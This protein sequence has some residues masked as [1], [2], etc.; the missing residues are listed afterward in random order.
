MIVAPVHEGSRPEPRLG[1]MANWRQFA[2]L[3]VVNGFVGGMVGLERVVVPLL[4]EREFGIASKS[5]TL[6]FIASFGLMKALT[7]LFAGQLSD[8]WG[9]KPLLIAGWVVGL[10]VP[11]LVILAPT[12]RWIVLA[13][14]LLGVN[15]GLCW[16]MTVVMK[17]D[18]TGPARRGLAM[19][20]N[21]VAG[22]L[23]V[24]GA[25]LLSGYLAASFTGRAVPFLPGIVFAVLGLLL[26]LFG[27]KETHHHA[28]QEAGTASRENEPSL[29]FARIVR[30]T[31]WQDRSLFATSQAG[32]VNNLNDSL[33]WGM[34]PL[35]FATARLPLGQ[36]AQLAAIYPA[37]W[38]MSQLATGP[39]SDW[40][41]RKWL[42]A[43]GMALQGGM[44]ML[45]PLVT[46]FWPW[47][48]ALSLL[49]LGTAM[50][51]PT[52][53]A[54]IGDVAHPNWRASA[55]GVYRLWR[56]AGYIVGALIAGKVADIAG[57]PVAIQVVGLVTVLS[58]AIVA[59]AMRE[60]LHRS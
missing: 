2:L 52:L 19:S 55:V 14:V 22:Y 17:I 8:R 1:L 31:S 20:L 48:G 30:R 26:S 59:G 27:I 50:V 11:L 40:L 15:Q 35:F 57:M 54:A 46:G 43:S 29:S 38:G 60:T 5:V 33:A 44:I 28:R 39:V 58:G 4:A 32:L 56:D 42:I 10:F 49:G 7:N 25:A 9:R 24:A 53:L 37:V 34:L 41:G 6:S 36:M 3:V 18:L 13:N 45:I 51:Y 23:A 47:A 16:S 12:W 21:E